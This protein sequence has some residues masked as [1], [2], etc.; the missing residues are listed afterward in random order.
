[1]NRRL[2]GQETD[3]IGYW[4]FDNL[5][6]RDYSRFG[7]HGRLINSPSQAASPLMG[8]SPLAGL[9]PVRAVA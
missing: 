7:R 9:R 4:H 2:G 6:A 5:E 1:M 8:Y 3:L